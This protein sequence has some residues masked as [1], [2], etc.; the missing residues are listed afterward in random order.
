MLLTMIHTAITPKKMKIKRQLP[1][2]SATLSVA[3]GE[4]AVELTVDIVGNN[5]P[6]AHALHD[7]FFERTQLAAVLLHLGA[8][9]FGAEAIEAIAADETG[10]VPVGDAGGDQG[11]D[12]FADR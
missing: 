6:L 9:E 7:R 4:G 12:I 3:E 8:D 2:N 1:P 10:R 5:Q 11:R